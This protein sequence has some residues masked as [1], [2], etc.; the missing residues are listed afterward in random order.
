MKILTQPVLAGVFAV[1]I[2]AVDAWV[3]HG[4]GI[5]WDKGLVLAGVAWIGGVA[6]PS[7]FARTS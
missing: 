5:E 7:P 6:V 3:F 1:V 2:G 4:F